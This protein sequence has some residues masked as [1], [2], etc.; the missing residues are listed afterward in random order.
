MAQTSGLTIRQ[1]EREDVELRVHFVVSEDHREQVR[2]SPMSAAEDPHVA[3]GKATD[4][5]TGGMGLISPQFIP[6][7]CEGVVRVYDP[8]PVGKAS[9]GSPVHEV[10]FEHE[11]K[12]RR[13]FMCSHEPMY[14]IGVA[15]L[16]VD[17]SLAEKVNELLERGGMVPSTTEGG[18]RGGDA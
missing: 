14:A 9:D 5:S 3:S 1:H 13:V 2:F 6:R 4:I 16:N 10:I 12:V 18:S 8:I 7:M 17:S 15:F 11:V